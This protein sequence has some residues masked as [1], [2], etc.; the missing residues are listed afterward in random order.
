MWTRLK[1]TAEIMILLLLLPGSI[2]SAAALE[3]E[4]KLDV[5][6]I[7]D[8]HSHLNSFPTVE[9]EE[10]VILGGYA[11]IS[12]LIEEKKK[13]NPDTLLLDGGDF[14]MG[15]LIQTVFP[16]ECAELRM[17][18]SIGIDASTLG[19]HEYDYRSKGLADALTTAK[20]SGDPLP[21]L[22]LSNAD[23]KA[24]EA[25]GLTEDQ[26][27]LKN[28]F[29]E[30]GIQ[31][32]TVIEKGGV[33]IALMGIFGE[34]A[35]EDAP[36]CALLFRDPVEAAKETVDTILENEDADM[37]I[38]LS[39]SGT[40]PD[41]ARSPDELLAKEV[42]GIDLIISAHSHT[43]IE[44]PIVY[45]HTYVVSCGEYGKKLGSLT[46]TQNSDGTWT[47]EDYE[48][49]PVTEDIPQD[50]ETQKRIDAFMEAVDSG[51]LSDFGYQRE[52][53]IAENDVTF[54][55]VNDLAKKFE[56]GNLGCLI[57]DAYRYAADELAGD[58]GIG[59]DVAV[60]P[61]GTVRETYSAGNVTVEDIY[62]SFSLGIGPDG[63]A[64]Y[65]LLCVY[66]TGAE[67]RTVAEIDAS[68]ADLKTAAR[69]YFSG[70]NYTF[71]PGR[72]ILNRVT[73]THLTDRAQEPLEID[74]KKLY[75]VV[76]DLYTG[77]M[78]GSITG[79]SYGLLSI[80]PKNAQGVPYENLED[81]ILRFPDG[82][83]LK[84]WDAIVRYMLS[85]EDTDG[86]GKG[87]IPAF[88]GEPLGRKT[89]DDS[90]SI[91]S[92]IRRPNRFAFM[93]AAVVIVLLLIVILVIRLIIRIIKKCK[94][95]KKT[96]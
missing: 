32:Y 23:W 38:C 82:R 69:L 68:I 10:E 60:C 47:M 41:P 93:L 83:E 1:R 49:I 8:T 96:A 62:Q 75:S 28:A 64:G 3:P 29:D 5:L 87:N 9:D 59:A 94:R 15:T 63:T 53:V 35:L 70:L 14:S 72:L 16:G 11:R 91:L 40:T 20:N 85:F 81:A 78:L 71:H 26:Q 95:K 13:E 74:D 50:A 88:Y 86:S 36:T 89:A 21:A 22:V 27:L 92:L 34:D 4:K 90:R 66:L 54:C 79:L 17:L 12:T 24:M 46:M 51:Y 48:L 56:D 2:L 42:P 76:S 80:K 25:A 52:D 57:A 33:R 61:A 55:T 39:H 37:I 84:A 73:E 43:V 45:G 18:G 19:N 6:F 67:L 65:P 7:H 58:S 31:D 44:E 30:Y 77:Q